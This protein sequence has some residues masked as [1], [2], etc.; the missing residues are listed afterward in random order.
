LKNFKPCKSES[1]FDEKDIV[2]GTIKSLERKYGSEDLLKAFIIV[3]NKYPELPLKL[4]LVGRG[5]LEEPLKK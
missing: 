2:I 1:L 4:L 5:S 3:K